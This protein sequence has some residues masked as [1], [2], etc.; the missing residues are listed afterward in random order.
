MVSNLNKAQKTNLNPFIIAKLDIDT[1]AHFDFPSMP[2]EAN[3][4][5]KGKPSI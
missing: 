2:K 1:I 4:Y 3:V 5:V